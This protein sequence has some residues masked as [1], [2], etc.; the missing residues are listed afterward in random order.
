MSGVIRKIV[1]GRG[2][3][4]I[5]GDDDVDYFFHADDLQGVEFTRLKVG[6]RLSFTPKAG[7]KGRRALEIRVQDL[8]RS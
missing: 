6:D 2:F 7:S 1:V 4:F 5:T 3:C 8:L